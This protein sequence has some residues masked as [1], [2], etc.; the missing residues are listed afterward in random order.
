RGV[1][2]GAVLVGPYEWVQQLDSRRFYRA[3]LETAIIDPGATVT[4]P[5]DERWALESVL[6]GSVVLPPGARHAIELVPV[7][8]SAHAPL[9]FYGTP[10]SIA[11]DASGGYELPAGT[12][13]PEAL[14]LRVQTRLGDLVPG[15]DDRATLAV[16]GVGGTQDPRLGSIEL[17]VEGAPAD[18][19]LRAEWSVDAERLPVP[20]DSRVEFTATWR[21][22]RPLRVPCIPEGPHRVTLRAADE[23]RTVALRAL[24]G[25]VTRFRY[26]WGDGAL[27]AER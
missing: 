13:R 9:P 1:L 19:R 24:A 10:P 15:T 21:A 25:A 6:R 11:L 5:Y 12:P 2:P 20:Q 4:L 18:A 3:G 14:V 22:A 23:V 26:S 7:Y 27:L 17:L 16:L 8:G